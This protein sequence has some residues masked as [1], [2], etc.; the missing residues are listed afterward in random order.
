MKMQARRVRGCHYGRG[1][2]GKGFH[3]PSRQL[4]AELDRVIALSPGPRE[5]TWRNLHSYSNELHIDSAPFA[6]KLS[7][8]HFAAT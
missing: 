7:V 5:Q 8:P 6:A 3:R 2:L 1:T 4:R